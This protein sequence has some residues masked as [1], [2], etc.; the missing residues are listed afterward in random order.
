MAFSRSIKD[1]DTLI[2]CAAGFFLICL[3]T[4]YSGIGISPDSIMYT[5]AARSFAT[6][7]SLKTFNH[8]PIVD[9][10]VFYPLFLG[11][12]TVISRIDPVAFG[13][14]L[15]ATLFASLLYTSG[16]IMNR[17]VPSSQLYKWLMLVAIALSPGLLQIY[18]YLW[19]ETLFIIEV[20]FFIIA[21]RQYLNTHTLKWLVIAAVIAAISCITRY[22]AVTIVGTGGLLLLL[23]RTLTIKRKIGHIVIYGLICISLLVANLVHN[24]LV[25]GTVTGP[26]EP[27]ITP[28]IDNL[29][30]FGT[31]M[32]DWAGF[33]P[34]Q[35]FLAIPIASVMLLGF[36]AALTYNFYRRHLNSYENLAITFS[37]VYGLFIILSSTF[38]RYERINSRLLS[39]LYL[40]TLWG[41]T[42][43][44]LL[45]LKTIQMKRTRMIVGAVFT[46]LMLG[47]CVKEFI[48]D[49]K[50]YKDQVADEY[51]APGYTDNSWAESPMANYLRTMDKKLFDP[52]V[53]V[54]TDA[55]EAVYFFSGMSSYLV[56]HVF[57]K[58]NIKR[59]MDTRRFYLIWFKALENKELITLPDIQKQK[60]LRLIK[61]FG[62]EGAIYEYNGLDTLKGSK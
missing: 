53:I 7:G 40:T 21:F 51:G 3:F 44:A 47:F 49:Y 39:P 9:F 25:T 60:K 18:S 62:E 4:S 13:A 45:W 10:P 17:F 1:L 58:D 61:D 35:Y 43:W 32:C 37:L 11:C 57:F 20:L 12:I 28:F 33:T 6:D 31:V 48:I 24:A 29:Y 19:S 23:D 55:H 36:I 41:Y 50:R 8:I 2:A 27:S 30:Y 42:S 46:L 15:N 26:R 5:S 14:V 38:S 22:A 16:W 54:Y 56:P 59:F 52:K 34:N